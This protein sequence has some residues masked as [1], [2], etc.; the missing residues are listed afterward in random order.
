[1]RRSPARTPRRSACRHP[2]P[3][4]VK[5]SISKS[6]SLISTSSAPWS[7]LSGR[8]PSHCSHAVLFPA[9][10]PLTGGLHGSWTQGNEGEPP[11]YLFS[12]MMLSQMSVTLT[13]SSYSACPPAVGSS[14]RRCWPFSFA[15]L[16]LL[17]T[18]VGLRS[19]WVVT[20]MG[21]PVWR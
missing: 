16:P 18:V 19:I 5:A 15:F 17:K 20:S 12:H 6:L 10:L 2:I 9:P 14:P 13:G 21:Y 3:G 11:R 1:M 7:M 4:E 8:V